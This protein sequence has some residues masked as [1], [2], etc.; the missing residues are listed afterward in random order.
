MVAEALTSFTESNCGASTGHATPLT[1]TV[2]TDP[3]ASATPLAAPAAVD[4][5]V[6]R[7]T[8]TDDALEAATRTMPS[9][10]AR[11]PA[12]RATSSTTRAPRVRTSTFT[13]VPLD[14]V[15]VT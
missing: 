10:A 1:A 5:F 8:V 14:P 6:T 9:T 13:T 15:A 2:R 4:R 7:R 11:A 3:T 12:G